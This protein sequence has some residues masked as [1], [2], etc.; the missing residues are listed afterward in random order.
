VDEFKKIDEDELLDRTRQF[1]VGRH[2]PNTQKTYDKTHIYR[3]FCGLYH[4]EPVPLP[5]DPQTFE[6]QITKYLTW[7][8]VAMDC[9]HSA[10]E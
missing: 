1:I 7:R 8:I 3:L 2:A 5:F 6:A 9:S 4:Y 10:R